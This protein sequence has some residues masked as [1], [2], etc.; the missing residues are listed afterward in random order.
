[1]DKYLAQICCSFW[2]ETIGHKKK[3]PSE[4]LFE[5]IL[6]KREGGYLKS[7]EARKAEFSSA[8]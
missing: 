5:F 7:N 4:K 1:M 3:S 8:K 2:K 6:R